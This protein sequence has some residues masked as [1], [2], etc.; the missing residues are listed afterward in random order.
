MSEIKSETVSS[1]H[2]DPKLETLKSEANEFISRERESLTQFGGKIL[3]DVE[4]LLSDSIETATTRLNSMFKKVETVI[5]TEPLVALTA[6]AITGVALVNLIRKQAE[7]RK[8]TKS[9]TGAGASKSGAEEA[10]F[11]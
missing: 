10:H 1:F 2:V 9:A 8:S 4:V 3:H 6:V 5:R 11:H 7:A